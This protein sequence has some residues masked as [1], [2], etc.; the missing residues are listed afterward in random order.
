MFN[1]KKEIQMKKALIAVAVIAGLGFG[2]VMATK[3]FAHDVYLQGEAKVM[4]LVDHAKA[5]AATFKEEAKPVIEEAKV[6]AEETATV[7]AEKADQAADVVVEKVE[8]VIEAVKI[9][10]S[11]AKEFIDSKLEEPTTTDVVEPVMEQAIALD[12]V[13]A[14]DLA[15]A[16]AEIVPAD[17]AST[18]VIE[19]GTERAAIIEPIIEAQA[20]EVVVPVA[21]VEEVAIIDEPT[22]IEE[23]VVVATPIVIEEPV[24]EVTETETK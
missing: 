5:S 1:I 10:A 13:V 15:V 3:H 17:D 19:E 22:V 21:T 9:K 12:V 6:K 7:V 14:E 11:E 16:Q 23:P 4:A 24:V 20:E 8:P 18:V 2:S